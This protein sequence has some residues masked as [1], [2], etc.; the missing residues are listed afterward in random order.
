M[1]HFPFLVL[2]LLL[3]FSCQEQEYPEIKL[4]R[5]VTKKKKTFD[6][7]AFSK[8][9]T[10]S[11]NSGAKKDEFSDLRP[12]KQTGCDTEEEMKKKKVLQPG[13]SIPD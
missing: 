10:F 11:G 8:G 3:L 6:D 12:S 2:A 7:F 13:C 9:T 1:K 5:T 4:Q